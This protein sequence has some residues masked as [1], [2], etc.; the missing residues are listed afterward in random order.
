MIP[1][2]RWLSDRETGPQCA[3]SPDPEPAEFAGLPQTPD[4]DTEISVP[5]RELELE[6]A[7]R[8]AEE[9]LVHERLSHAQREQHLRNTLGMELVSAM[10]ALISDGLSAMKRDLET[11]IVDVLQ[12]F[13]TKR[14]ATQAASALTELM[15]AELRNED[16]PLLGI[17]APE[18]LHEL[19]R[20]ALEQMGVS[21]S[22]SDGSRIELAFPSRKARFEQLASRWRE[23]IL[24]TEV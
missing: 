7:L 14:A 15:A 13:L 11:A 16:Q 24:E 21:A 10:A 3:F 17:R 20:P 19:M 18:Q 23:I 9:S 12:P 6:D 4:G 8:T 1:L 5:G 2:S 22:L